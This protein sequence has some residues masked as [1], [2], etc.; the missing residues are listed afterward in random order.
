[1]IEVFLLNPD[2]QNEMWELPIDSISWTEEL[3]NVSTGNFSLVYKDLKELAQLIGT[4]V[5]YILEGGRRQLII[6]DENY[7]DQPILFKGFLRNDQISSSNKETSTLSLNFA[8]NLI[9]LSKRKGQHYKF[10]ENNP[11]GLIFKEQL[12][13]AQSQ[14]NGNMLITMANLPQTTNR[15]R[16][17]KRTDLLDLLIGMSKAKVDDGF[18]FSINHNNVLT[19]FSPYKGSL[20]ENI[21]LDSRNS[22]QPQTTAK[23]MGELANKIYVQGGEL[24]DEQGNVKQE[25]IEVVVEDVIS[26]RKWGLHEDYISAT[27]IATEPFLRKRGIT[28]LN[29]KSTPKKTQTVSLSHL[30]D[31]PDWRSYSIGDWLVIDLPDLNLNEPLRVKKRSINYTKGIY[32][33][34]LTLIEGKENV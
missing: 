6:K 1:M 22:L 8:D 29:Q 17:I 16:T 30:G 32:K 15:Q 5:N 9:M 10:Y 23:L 25:A 20:K 27:D 28:V 33:I 13:F 14:E 2:N 11:S 31:D 7:S 18:D 12:D 3:N 19:L 4:T 34:N 24:T 26:Q 21:V